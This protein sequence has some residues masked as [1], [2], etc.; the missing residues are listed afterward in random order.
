MDFGT[1]LTDFF[2][3]GLFA[4]GI[5]SFLILPRQRAFRE[6]QKLVSQLAV[7]T[8]VITYGGVIGKVTQIEAE[9]GIVHL[10]IA[11]GVKVRVLAQAISSEYQPTA[12]AESAQKAMK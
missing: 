8:D 9:Q 1:L 10:E 4:I 12:I 7:G 6:R 3:I 11:P 5:Y 2:I